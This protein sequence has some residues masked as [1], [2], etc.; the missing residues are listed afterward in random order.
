MPANGLKAVTQITE[1]AKTRPIVA[2]VLALII[3]ATFNGG[4]SYLFGSMGQGNE[5]SNELADLKR[6]DTYL[7]SA[8]K[9]ETIDRVREITQLKEDG[10][11][12]SEDSIRLMIK[13][14]L[15]DFE[16]RLVARLK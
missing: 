7:K 1:L 9:Q 8:I 4:I 10:K 12:L 6:Q 5:I 16:D 2:I 13:S 11:L 14:E 3:L 15:Q